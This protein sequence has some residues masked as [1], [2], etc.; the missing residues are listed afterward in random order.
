[1][2]QMS[3]SKQVRIRTGEWGSRANDKT[4]SAM[5]PVSIEA[6]SNNEDSPWNVTAIILDPFI[7][8]ANVTASCKVSSKVGRKTA[9]SDSNSKGIEL[10]NGWI[11]QGNGSLIST[12]SSSGFGIDKD[13]V[14]LSHPKG[15]AFFQ[16]QKSVRCTNLNISAR[17]SGNYK[18]RMR[19][20]N[21][22]P[23][24]TPIISRDYYLSSGRA[25]VLNLAEVSNT[26]IGNYYLLSVYSDINMSIGVT[27]A[28]DVSCST[29]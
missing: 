23:N 3:Y 24:S 26:F 10:N 4:Y 5:L 27:N 13:V 6:H 14:N 11:W 28:I 20:W 21:V 9:I 25:T 17:I 16:W 19:G 7:S 1:M 29:F 18:L 12:I 15:A 2:E 22:S 8:P